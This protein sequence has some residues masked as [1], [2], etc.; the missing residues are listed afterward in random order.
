MIPRR[1]K[2]IDVDLCRF[3]SGARRRR[4]GLPLQ[5][6][7]FPFD[8]PAVTARIPIAADDPV[9]GDGQGEGIRRARPGHGAS[10][11]GIPDPAGDLPVTRRRSGGDPSK[12]LP[13][14]LLEGRAANV[15]RKVQTA[16]RRHDRLRH[17]AKP[18]DGFGIPL[19]ILPP[20]KPGLEGIDQGPPG[21]AQIDGTEAP[22]G[23][24]DENPPE[25][26]PRN[27]EADRLPLL[28]G[29]TRC[30]RLAAVLSRSLHA[31]FLHGDALAH[32]HNNTKDSTLSLR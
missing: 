31:L 7:E 11:A 27:G 29:P 10:R 8:P 9:T 6:R 18:T 19:G 2:R 32:S 13:D 30:G 21:I 16:P 3:P 15:Q 12:L 20:A 4:S 5:Q 26:G 22:R 28:P 24:G 25:V 14:F 23:S 1:E 17:P